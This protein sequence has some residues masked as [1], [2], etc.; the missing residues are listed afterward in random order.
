[1]LD[2]PWG[3]LKACR[4]CRWSFYDDR[5][6]GRRRGARCSSAATA[7]RL[8]PTGAPEPVG[9][10]ACGRGRR[11]AGFALAF[12]PGFA[13]SRTSALS[14]TASA[15]YGIG[16]AVVGLFTTAL[17][18]THA[19]MQVPAGRLCDR[20][21]PRLVGGAGLVVV[22]AGVPPGARPARDVVCDRD[23]APRRVS[24]LAA[25][26]RRRSRLRP[27]DPRLAGCPGV[28]RRECAWRRRARPRPRP[29]LT[30]PARAVRDG[31]DRRRRRSRAV[32]L[33][34]R[35]ALPSRPRPRGAPAFDRRLLPL[36]VMHAA[37][38]GLSVV[39]GNWGR[40]AARAARSPTRPHLSS[41]IGSLVLFVGVVSRPLGGRLPRAAGSSSAWASSRAASVSRCSL[42][43]GHSPLAAAAAAVVGL[44]S[45]LPFAAGVRGRPAARPT[46]LPRPS[47]SSTSRRRSS[48]SSARR[49]SA[50]RFP[51]LAADASDSLLLQGCAW[52]RAR[53]IETFTRLRRLANTGLGS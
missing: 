6:T 5:R 12:T 23:A 7:R 4:N 20:F 8:G 51:Y 1:M 29:A 44:A 16:L 30:G 26:V 46:R 48:S 34:P 33:A 37:S 50:S 9:S 11:S 13:T 28:F 43:T 36:A 47:G 52:L 49:S 21:G 27:R 18:V 38:F 25:R 17:F 31:I 35:D 14:P 15:A 3:R 45:G 24:A 41:V 42:R 10:R 40:D 32:A 22:A 39:I 19:A 2:G 53:V